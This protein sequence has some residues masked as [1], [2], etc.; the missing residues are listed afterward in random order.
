MGE[1]LSIHKFSKLSG[2]GSSTLRYW[3]DLGVFSPLMRH[4]SNNYRY[5]SITQ[6]PELNFVTTLCELQVPLKTIADIQNGRNPERILDLLEEHERKLDHEM[7]KLQIQYSIIHSRRELMA[8]GL[9]ANEA[10]ISVMALPEKNMLRWPRNEY[11]EG[12]TFINPLVS[13]VSKTDDYL[14]NLSFPI[15]GYHETLGSFIER[16]G[17]PDFF[18]SVDPM[19]QYK[20]VS[21]DYLVAYTRGYYGEFGDL[22]TRMM[23]YAKEHS[24]NIIGPIYTVYLHEGICTKDPSDYL[25]QCSILIK[26]EKTRS[27]P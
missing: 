9:K 5:Y 3:D 24:I 21:G 25:A 6:L 7:A 23:Q 2:V 19:G 4:P 26:R 27:R 17:C 16:P 22:P 8:L 10:E 18:L 13:H 1:T 14:I 12:D 11:E 20:R 15:A